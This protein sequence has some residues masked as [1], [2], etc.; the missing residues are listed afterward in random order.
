VQ[1]ATGEA[2]DV[3]RASGGDA[4]AF[5][6]LYEAHVGRVH[7][8]ALRMAGPEGAED[9]TQEVFIRA[10]ERLHTFRGEARFGTW[11]HRLAVHYLL[12]ARKRRRRRE[13]R[14]VSGEGILD[15]TAAPP[16]RST[17]VALDLEAAIRT[18]PEGARD[19]FV[20]YDVEGYRHKEIAELMGISVGT[21][22]SQLHR[23]RMLLRRHLNGGRT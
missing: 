1:H 9:L 21:S 16:G 18:L 15:R 12:S 10:W 22:K 23:A 6:R 14:Q 3:R 19:V 4:G 7:A 2:D 17:A 8:L 20:L 13:D 11:L 5:R